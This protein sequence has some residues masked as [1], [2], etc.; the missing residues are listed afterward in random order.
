MKRLQLKLGSAS[1]SFLKHTD[2]SV[3]CLV[4][5]VFDFFGKHRVHTRRLLRN[6]RLQR[7][8][9]IVRKSLCFQPRH[10]QRSSSGYTYFRPDS[11]MSLQDICSLRNRYGVCEPRKIR[12]RCCLFSER[13]RLK[14]QNR[15]NPP[16]LRPRN[17][18]L[19][20][21]HMSQFRLASQQNSLYFRSTRLG[22]DMKESCPL[23]QR[24]VQGVRQIVQGAFSNP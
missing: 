3:D 16:T 18:Q 21:V 13:R 20:C 4:V 6:P 17:C 15:P 22:L 5:R 9:S 2:Q 19:G 11:L 24:T 1:R 23:L 12:L 14:R 8:E 10:R 7:P